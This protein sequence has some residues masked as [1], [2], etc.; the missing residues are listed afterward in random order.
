MVRVEQQVPC[1]ILMLLCLTVTPT[2][3]TFTYANAEANYF[4]AKEK[5]EEQGLVLAQ[6]CSSSDLQNAISIC[7]E[8]CYFSQKFETGAWVTGCS[9]SY[10]PPFKVEEGTDTDK[11]S[12]IRSNGKQHE[13]GV[14]STRC[15]TERGGA[16][17]QP[18]PT[19][20]ST[21]SDASSVAILYIPTMLALVLLEWAAATL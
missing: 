21:A 3:G 1:S 4:G 17:C 2:Q 16:V 6:I 8:D 10:Q 19:S 13:I 7:P 15:T 9:N 12:Y 11:C 18:A 14:W 20:S 5:C